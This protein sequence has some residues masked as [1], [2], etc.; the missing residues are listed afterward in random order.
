VTNE[1]D[2]LNSD[3]YPLTDYDRDILTLRRHARA[4][5]RDLGAKGL[6]RGECRN[7]LVAIVNAGVVDGYD[8]LAFHREDE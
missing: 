8:D 6:P 1:T 4:I 7:A 5:A 2:L 3:E